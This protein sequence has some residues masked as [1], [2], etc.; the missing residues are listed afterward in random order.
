MNELKQVR[1]GKLTPDEKTELKLE[2]VGKIPQIL[3]D[4][5]DRNRTSPF[6]FTGNKFEIRAVGSSANCASPMTILNTIVGYQLK[7]FLT[8]YEKM[9][10]KG[11]KKDEAIFNILRDYIKSSERILFEGNGYSEEWHREAKKRGLSNLKTTPEALRVIKKDKV[12]K[13]FEE[14]GVYSRSELHS[15]Y[16][17]HLEQY[18]T[19]LEIEAR[20]LSD[21]VSNHVVPTVI[22]YLN[23]LADSL[24]GMKNLFPENKT[25]WQ[26][27]EKILTEVSE[28]FNA[29]LTKH[30]NLK[31]AIEKLQ[32][33]TDQDR[34]ADFIISDIK[35]LM[36]EVRHLT[37][38]LELMI[39]DELWSL[40]KYREMLFTR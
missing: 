36:D 18:N 1:N 39:D 28:A 20:V 29:L 33:F 16:H 14:T 2:V 24:T 23:R 26:N 10:A 32:K 30:E 11:L 7:Q 22:N 19:K 17:V 25:F 5:T 12:I 3:K 37:D 4:N 15:R 21:L 27:N 8:D 9:R 31:T 6:A 13:L 35:P 34:K 40:V 38:R